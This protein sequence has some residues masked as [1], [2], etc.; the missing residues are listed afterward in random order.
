MIGRGEVL[1][2][3]AQGAEAELSGGE[4]L[5]DDRELA[6]VARGGGPVGGDVFG[7][8]QGLP[9]V[10]VEGPIPLLQVQRRPRVERGEVRDQ[11]GAGLAFTTGKNGDAGE[12][13]AVGERL[14][15]REMVLLHA[16]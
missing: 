13:V 12:E 2:E 8:V 15:E 5:Q 6:A 14:G 10:A 1:A 7:E 9:A 16:A 11:V 4:P 3:D